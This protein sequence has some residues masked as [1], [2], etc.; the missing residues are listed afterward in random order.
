MKIF[1]IFSWLERK[2]NMFQL[3][4]IIYQILIIILCSGFSIKK[5]SNLL[6]IDSMSHKDTLMIKSTTWHH[7]RV[8]DFESICIYYEDDELVAHL[9]RWFTRI[10]E[11]M[12]DTIFK[13]NKTQIEGIRLFEKKVRNQ[14]LEGNEIRLSGRL[15]KYELTLKKKKVTY[16]TVRECYRFC[17]EGW[18]E[19]IMVRF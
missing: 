14:N 2:G 18:D 19:S 13:L 8:E 7:E 16:S 4:I 3:K 5:D 9:I 15:T 17:G 6:F 12:C 1:I 11:A 10:D